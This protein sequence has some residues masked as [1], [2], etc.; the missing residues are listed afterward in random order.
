MEHNNLIKK[1]VVVAVILLFV[2]VSVIPSTGNRVFFDDITPPVTTCT[3]NPPEPN[4]NNSWYVSDVE[5]TLNAT[6]DMSGVNVTQF[7]VDGGSI[8]TYTEPFNI[9]TDGEHTLEYRS[10]DY[11]GNVEDWKSVEFKIDQTLPV[12]DLNYEGEYTINTDIICEVRCMDDTSGIDKVEFYLDESLICTDN[13]PPYKCII[14]RAEE[15]I[16]TA[17]GLIFNPQFSEENITFFAL[18]VTGVIT[19]PFQPPYGISAKAYDIAGNSGYDSETAPPDENPWGAVFK[20]L[21]FLNNYVGY[22]GI[23]LINARFNP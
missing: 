23:F 6:D 16:I 19:M 14:L 22:I 18:I 17:V 4:G 13:E 12:L 7:R 1:G 9:S 15:K 11:A 2:S 3:L 8:H 10:I 20:R 5:V 21:T